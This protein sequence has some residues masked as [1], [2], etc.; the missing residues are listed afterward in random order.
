M[1]ALKISAFSGERPLIIPRLLPETSGQRAVNI[2]MDDGG[3]T[4][5]NDSVPI[6]LA[7][8]KNHKTIYQHGDTWLS[9][10]GVVNAVPGPVAND[11]LYYTGDGAPKMRVAATVYPLAVPRPVP[12]L[13]PT[14]GGSGSGD[15]ATRIYV[16]TWVT[17]FDE[18]SEPSPASAPV[19]WQS[20]ETVTL[21]GFPATPAGRNINRQRIYRSQTGRSGTYLYLIAERIA[22]AADFLDNIPVDVFQEALPSANWN[23]PPDGLLGLTMMPNGMMSAFSGRDIYFCEPFRPHAWPESYVL[24][25]D[26][27]VVGLGSIGTLLVVMTKGKPYLISGSEPASLQMVQLEAN[28]PCLNARGIVDMGFAICYPTHDGLVS[29]RADGSISLVTGDIL[30]R[31]AWLEFSP[32]TLIGGQLSGRYVAFYDTIDYNGDLF[33]GAIF[34]ALGN[35]PFLIRTSTIAAAVFYDVT[36][37][38]LYFLARGEQN[39]CRFDS[40]QGAARPMYWRSKEYWLTAPTN[41]GAIL[42]DTGNEKTQEELDLL[43]LELAEILAANAALVEAGSILGEINTVAINEFALNGDVLTPVPNQNFIQI[44]IFADRKKVAQITTTN[45]I[46]RLPAGFKARLWEID[47]NSDIQVTQIAMATTVDELRQLG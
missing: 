42:V 21:S 7:G 17:G 13:T 24:S 31:K 43:A 30:S 44:G 23:T 9:W 16:F 2:R 38:A 40:P 6:A 46:T 47:V 15:V 27:D 20:G 18:E 35:N 41:F 12:A 22:S 45:R 19:D 36:R 1:V 14:I 29:V 28:F 32:E 3:L 8:D 4:P 25:C 10:S 33:A 34:I 5:I 37:S 26:S 11:R 39:I